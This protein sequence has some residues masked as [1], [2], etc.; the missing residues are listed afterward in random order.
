VINSIF[1]QA[2]MATLSNAEAVDTLDILLQAEGLAELGT[3]EGLQAKGM[4]RN[5]FGRT[6]LHYAAK[7]N[8]PLASTMLLDAMPGLLEVLHDVSI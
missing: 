5:M 3:E 7:F 6:P 4:L 1:D 8:N 2:D